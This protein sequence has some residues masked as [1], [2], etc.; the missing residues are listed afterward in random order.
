MIYSNN[1]IAA[2]KKQFCGKSS[3]GASVPGADFA[4]SSSEP[5]D[6]A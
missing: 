5:S 4:Q 2:L 6:M 1:F 3:G